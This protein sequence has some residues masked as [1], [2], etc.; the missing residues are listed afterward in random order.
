M[1]VKAQ[2]KQKRDINDG[3]FN[4]TSGHAAGRTVKRRETAAPA[5]APRIF[6]I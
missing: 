1:L 5:P 6:R 4:L 2:Q 3:S